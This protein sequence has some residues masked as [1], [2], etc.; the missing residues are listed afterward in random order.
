MSVIEIIEELPKLTA[1]EREEI[2]LKLIELDGEWLDSDDPLSEAD[3][4]LL[5][6][7][8]KDLDEH[9]GKSI[10]WFEAEA[11]LKARYGE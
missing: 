10:R 7:R 9:P 2:S 1:E 6:S 4:T 5:N 11:L 8:L 3:K